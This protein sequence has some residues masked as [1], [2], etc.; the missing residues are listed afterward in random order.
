[1]QF[2]L[3]KGTDNQI[4]PTYTVKEGEAITP[5]EASA[6]ATIDIADTL[7]EIRDLLHDLLASRTGL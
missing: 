3:Q 5:E 2:R 7:A 6:A 1:M 4:T